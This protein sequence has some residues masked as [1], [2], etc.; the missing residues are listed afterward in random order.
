[1]RC[2][3]AAQMQVRTHKRA[4][5]KALRRKTQFPLQAKQEGPE[6]TQFSLLPPLAQCLGNSMDAV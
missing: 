6:P 4:N 3:W 1:M 2:E 5:D